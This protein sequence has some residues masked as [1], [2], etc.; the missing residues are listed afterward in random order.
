MKA[1]TLEVWK[2]ITLGL[3]LIIG[4]NGAFLA[5]TEILYAIFY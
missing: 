2:G 4:V 5:I 3:A 1:N